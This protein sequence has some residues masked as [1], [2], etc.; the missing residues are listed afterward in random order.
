[1]H[2]GHIIQSDLNHSSSND[3]ELI[4][5]FSD[6]STPFSMFLKEPCGSLV[7]CRLLK[8]HS[9]TFTAVSFGVGTSLI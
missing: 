2:L 9:S 3:G 8:A 4:Y 6:L 5:D 1:M 7:L